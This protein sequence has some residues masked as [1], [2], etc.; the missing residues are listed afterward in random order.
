M[1][2]IRILVFHE[3]ITEHIYSGDIYVYR[4]EDSRT[5]K[6]SVKFLRIF[7][8]RP[9]S[10]T[11]VRLSPISTLEWST[12]G[13]ALACGWIK[14]GLSIW[15][16][17]GKCLFCTCGE[18]TWIQ[19]GSLLNLFSDSANEDGALPTTVPGWVAGDAYFAGVQDLVGDISFY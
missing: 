2:F 10:G 14:G 15:S 8:F 17:F 1:V 11:T 13:Y 12:D 9:P 5:A 18:D 4:F 7:K 6:M 3:L 16:V 19:S